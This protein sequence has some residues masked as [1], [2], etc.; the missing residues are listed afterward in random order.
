[1]CGMRILLFFIGLCKH[2]SD[3]LGRGRGGWQGV[4]LS[5]ARFFFSF[6]LLAI[7]ELRDTKVYE[8]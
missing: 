3:S 2:A 6:L 4:E 7:L 1:M 5:V 8:P